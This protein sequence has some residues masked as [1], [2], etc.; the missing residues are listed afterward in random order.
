MNKQDNIFTNALRL[1]IFCA[2][3]IEDCRD[4][5]EANPPKSSRTLRDNVEFWVEEFLIPS[6]EQAIEETFENEEDDE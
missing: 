2:D 6:L 3:L 5:Y 4:H 1:E